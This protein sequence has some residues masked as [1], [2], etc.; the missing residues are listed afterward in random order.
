MTLPF[1]NF[2]RLAS[3]AGS[4]TLARVAPV[5]AQVAPAVAAAILPDAAMAKRAAAKVVAQ[6]RAE[7]PQLLVV[8]VVDTL[9]G[10]DEASFTSQASFAPHL[11]AS[12]NAE[13]LKQKKRALRA[14]H[15]DEEQIEDIIIS[16]TSQHHIIK[17]VNNGEKFIY[18][19]VL[20]HNTS[21][22]FAREVLRRHAL[23]LVN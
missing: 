8:A 11:A 16:T 3:L 4:T 13:I 21:L 7:L 19:A 12:L 2:A 22:G 9:T 23:S 5:P 14:F 18:L 17:A 1:L 15:L 6:I 10:Q 20:E